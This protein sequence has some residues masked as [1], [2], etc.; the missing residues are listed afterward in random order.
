MEPCTCD[1]IT[2]PMCNGSKRGPGPRGRCPRCHGTGSAFADCL[3]HGLRYRGESLPDANRE[4][5]CGQTEDCPHCEG[6]G[7]NHLDE[8][9]VCIYLSLIHI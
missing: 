8:D 3:R 6:A 5:R 7:V 9:G 4:C 1:L 2:C